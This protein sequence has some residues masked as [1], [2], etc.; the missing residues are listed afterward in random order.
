MSAS[1]HWL[2]INTDGSLA[3]HTENDGATYLRRGPEAVETPTTLEKLKASSS[4]YYAE[5]V[6]GL[7]KLGFPTKHV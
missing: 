1:D 7:E 3:I 4:P 2:V 5:A 6:L